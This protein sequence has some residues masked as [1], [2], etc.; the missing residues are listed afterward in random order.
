MKG[1]TFNLIKNFTLFFILSLS[2][3]TVTAQTSEWAGCTPRGN[4]PFQHSV[5]CLFEEPAERAFARGDYENAIKFINLYRNRY[6]AKVKKMV[7]KTF[8]DDYYAESGWDYFM[9]GEMYEKGLG[10]E[11]NSEKALNLFFKC[12]QTELCSGRYWIG[13]SK[14][15]ILKF[16]E[17]PDLSPSESQLQELE[18]ILTRV[19]NSNREECYKIAAAEGLGIFYEKQNKYSKALDAYKKQLNLETS[20]YS[21]KVIQ[22]NIKRIE[23]LMK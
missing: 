18:T 23:K 17:T 11:Q 10:Y 6:D 13:N 4:G 8:G 1:N 14:K 12:I 3:F 5:C 20:K 21:Q 22:K 16:V 2:S 7:F 9:E 15:A 19:V